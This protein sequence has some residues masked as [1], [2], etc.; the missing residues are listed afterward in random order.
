VPCD[1][2]AGLPTRGLKFRRKFT[3]FYVNII[4]G[5]LNILGVQSVPPCLFVVHC[6]LHLLRGSC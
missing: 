2:T 6:W 3:Y 4:T 5:S 1:A